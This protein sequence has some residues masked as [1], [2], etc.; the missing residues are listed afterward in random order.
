VTRSIT[1]ADLHLVVGPPSR[2]PT[3]P[4]PVRPPAPAP[5]RARGRECDDCG[6]EM[7][8]GSTESESWRCRCG[9]ADELH[10]AQHEPRFGLVRTWVTSRRMGP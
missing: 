9:R 2:R 4:A 3:P 5:A 10:S 8:R 7:S 6:A 1:D